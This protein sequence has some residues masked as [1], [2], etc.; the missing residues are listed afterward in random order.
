MRSTQHQR[1]MSLI[2]IVVVLAV[3]GALTLMATFGVGDWSRDQRLKSAVRSVADGFMLARSEA[4]RSGRQH[5]LVFQNALGATAPIQIVNDGT[6]ATA[7]CTIGAGETVHTVAAVDGV[8]WGTSPTISGAT[9]APD[10]L[11]LAP[12][13]SVA[14]SSFSDASLNPAS[15]A[16]WVLFQPDGLPR[17]FTPNAGTC[18]AI[19]LAGQGG[20]AIYLSNGRRDYAVVLTALGTARVHVWDEQAGGWKR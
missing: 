9:P 16:S 10:D 5:L 2:E 1:G 7:D 20:G 3:V 4:I 12:A 19:G 13:F 14:G 11:G 8:S 18:G 15:S 17:L 6:I